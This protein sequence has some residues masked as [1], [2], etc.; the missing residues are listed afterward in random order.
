M[1]IR[2][3]LY[4]GGH[5][6]IGKP[7]G[8][9]YEQT[10][11]LD[12]SSVSEDI[13]T[14]LLRTMLQHC[15]QSVP[16]YAARMSEIG[17]YFAKDPEAYLV[18]LPILTKEI[19]REKIDHLSSNDLT[20]RKWYYNTSGGSTGEPIKLIQD[21][22][23]STQT[24]ATQI[25]MSA[26]AG[27]EFGEPAVLV[28]GSERDVREG[29]MGLKMRVLNAL[30]NDSWLNAYHLT[31]KNMRA[32]IE[33]INRKPPKV[34][35]AYVQAIYELAKFVEREGL[36]V[37]PQSA[38]MTSA[39]TLH[40]FMREKIQSVFQC[41]IFD[42]YGSREVGDIACE[43][44]AHT[45]LHVFPWQN[46]VEIVDE[47]GNGVPRG[48]EGNIV[49]T[50]LTNFAMPLIRYAIGD[51]GVLSPTETC[52]CGRK[53]QLLEQVAGRNVDMF[54]RR[55]GTLVSSGYFTRLLYFRDWVHKFQVIQKDYALIVFKI[56]KSA[57][58]YSPSELE[59]ITQK[60][61]AVMGT[62]C[63]VTF[64]FV[65]DIETS[66]SGKYRYTMSEVGG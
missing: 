65:D 2:K 9:V 4:V 11:K 8:R 55:D 14:H 25:L 52:S 30:S 15:Q 23:F 41:N 27:R 12:R 1:N 34:I 31:P 42:R 6:L 35:I 61:Q 53:G 13:M 21:S 19:I 51:R 17:G 45:G 22:D 24:I 47:A 18:Q 28:W 59:E 36:V 66:A 39:G 20:Q 63:T 49:V 58:D 48:T 37:R 3:A 50:S 26:W 62:P 32:L 16:Y 57:T 5:H 10:V 46:Y 60:T 40:P 38:I 33:T 7:V 56:V 43:C 54:R 64:E 44:Q 29:T